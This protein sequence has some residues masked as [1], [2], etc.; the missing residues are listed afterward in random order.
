MST[1]IFYCGIA[2]MIGAFT[3][4]IIIPLI[5]AF[6][7]KVGYYDQPNQRK[8]HHAAIPRLGG[9]A[10]LPAMATRYHLLEIYGICLADNLAS[11]RVM[12]KCGFVNLYKGIG[13]YQG[14]QREIVKNIWKA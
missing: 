11:V 1:Y 5:V 4:A 10:F 2:F 3:S 9:L 8:V 6:C 12:E 14:A 13:P 7:R